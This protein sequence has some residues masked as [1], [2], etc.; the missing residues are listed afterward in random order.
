[1]TSNGG[2]STMPDHTRPH[3]PPRYLGHQPLNRIDD[4]HAAASTSATASNSAAASNSGS[5]GPPTA[6]SYTPKSQLPTPQSQLPPSSALSSTPLAPPLAKTTS[7]ADSPEKPER[8]FRGWSRRSVRRGSVVGERNGNESKDN[9]GRRLSRQDSRQSNRPPSPHYPSMALALSVSTSAPG[10][11]YIDWDE[12]DPENPMNW[13]WPK[14]WVTVGCCFI[15]TGVTAVI[16]TA[17]NACGD[18]VTAEFGIDETV[19]LLGNTSYLV[20]VAIEIG[21]AHV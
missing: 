10:A 12:D 17:F 16:A 6:S 1:M 9:D 13:S 19:Y 4:D 3:E 18:A 14:K 8:P 5:S 20:A 15:F 11:I 21:R 2:E 7:F